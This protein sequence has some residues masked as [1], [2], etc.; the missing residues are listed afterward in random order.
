MGE[1]MSTTA[2]TETRTSAN[3]RQACSPMTRLLDMLAGWSAY[4]DDSEKAAESAESRILR[5]VTSDEISALYQ[6]AGGEWLK[7][8]ES[9]SAAEDA[10]VRQFIE[11][12]IL[13]LL[14][15]R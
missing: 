14:L 1:T 6:E 4:V 10:T 9:D 2:T 13:P 8:D 12:R 7:F 11:E 15:R 5:T 3:A